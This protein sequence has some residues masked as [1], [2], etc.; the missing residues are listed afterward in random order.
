MFLIYEYMEK[1]SLF[2]ALSNDMD[3]NE[4]DWTK[5]VNIIKGISHALSYMHHDCNPP[6]VHWDITSNNI[7][8]NSQLEASVSD[9]GIARLLDLESSNQT[10][11]V[12]TYGY[13]APGNLLYNFS[14]SFTYLVIFVWVMIIIF[15]NFKCLDKSQNLPTH[16]L[17]LKRVMFMAL[18]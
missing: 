14:Q 15:V 11:L 9:F 10:I 3:A 6:I 4:L 5:R 13:V 1:G 18:E 2:S 16:W 17:W 7:L 8:L 12:G